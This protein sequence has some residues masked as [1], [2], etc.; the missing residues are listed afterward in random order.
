MSTSGTV[1]FTL[2]IA[3]I[4][5]EAYERAGFELRTGYDARTARRSLNLLLTDWTNRGVNLW[6]VE[7]VTTTLTSGTN[8]YT[9]ATDTVDILEA[10]IRDTSGG[11]NSDTECDRISFEEYLNYPDKDV[12]GH[13]VQFATLRGRDAPTLFL[14]PTPNQTTF[15]FVH[16][17]IRQMEDID[18]M[19]QD[20]DVP[21]RFLPALVAGLAWEIA[22]KKPTNSTIEET[23]RRADAAKLRDLKTHYEELFARAAD[24]DRDRASLYL[25]PRVARRGGK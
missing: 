19:V 7:Q 5:E 12:T 11:N 21:N 24:E 6:T 20:P 18:A 3:D 13:P 8:Q 9:L 22:M 4:I 10:V 17:R 1:L 15:S 25:I 23:I 2:D 16:W 14:Y